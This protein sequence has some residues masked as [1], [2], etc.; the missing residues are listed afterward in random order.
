MDAAVLRGMAK[1]PNVPAV[2]GWLSLDGRGSWFIKGDRV[3]NPTLSAFISRNYESDGAGR[4][5][6][7]NGPQRVFV[8]IQYTPFVYRVTNEAKS[9]LA[10]ESHTGLAV[11]ALSGAWIDEN[12]ALLIETEHGIGTI[13]DRDLDKM[14]AAL[15]DANGASAPEAVLDEVTQLMQQG[16]A[17]PLWLQFGGARVKVD[18]ITSAAVPSRFGFDAEPAA[19][20]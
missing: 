2:Y 6:F 18:P 17:A 9:P 5:F 3:T 10:I 16:E 11:G 8:A 20:E 12:G 14:L 4:W 15:V 13:D 1:W 7:Q 19:D